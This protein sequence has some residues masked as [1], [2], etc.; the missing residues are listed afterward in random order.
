MTACSSCILSLSERSD[1]ISIELGIESHRQYHPWTSPT[2]R[3]SCRISAAPIEDFDGQKDF[4]A[5]TSLEVAAAIAGIVAAG[6]GIVF[7]AIDHWKSSANKTGETVT[8]SGTGIASG[9]DTIIN[10]PVFNTQSPRAPTL[11]ATNNGAINASGAQIPETFP[12]PFAKADG[13]FINMP[14]LRVTPGPDGGYPF[15]VSPSNTPQ[16]VT[17]D[18]TI[19]QAGIVVGKAFGARRL[20]NDAT[21]F[22]FREITNAAQFNPSAPFTY[23]GVKMIFEKEDNSAWMVIG[24]ADSP[25]RWGVIARVLE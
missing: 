14:N 16:P 13:G 20:P 9:R 19:Y 2:K 17:P 18:D 15:T 3:S 22:E 6:S 23:S 10:G 21:R 25:I 11:E 4:E 5:L 24:R 8:Q 1:R 7:W 12:F